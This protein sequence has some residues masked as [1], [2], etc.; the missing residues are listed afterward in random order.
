MTGPSPVEYVGVFA[1]A[2]LLTLLFVPLA[3]RVVLRR[4]NQRPAEVDAVA[5]ALPFFGGAAI[6]VAFS[7]IVFVSAL[8]SPPATQIKQLA[9]ALA[10]AVVLSLV[11]LIDDVRGVPATARLGAIAGASIGIWVVGVRIDLFPFEALNLALTIAWVVG[12]TTAFNL[13]DNIDGLSAGV[14]GIAGASFFV[15]AFTNHQYSVAALSAAL[16]G[17]AAGFLR[18]N[19][20]PA[21][22]RMGDAGSLFLGFLLSVIGIKLRFEA[23]TAVTFLVPVL[24]LGLAI[25]DTTLVVLT[26][27]AGGR[28]PFE[29]G[30][31]HA[32]HRLVAAGL[33]VPAALAL[34]YFA[35]LALGW[36]GLVTARLTD[37]ATAYLLAALPLLIGVVGGILLASS[38]PMAPP[39]VG[40]TPMGAL[41]KRAFDIVVGS[42]IALLA[43]P[44]IVALAVVSAV[45]LRAWPFFM[46]KRIGRHGRIFKFLKIRTLPPHAAPYALKSEFGDLQIPRFA[47]FL[48]DRHLDELPQLYAVPLGRM[49]LVGPRPK[50]PDEF[51]PVPEEYARLRTRVPQG[52]TCLWQV[53]VHTAGLP[54]DSPEY[55]YWYLRHWS[56][57]LDLWILWRTALTLVGAGREMSLEDVPVWMV[58]RRYAI[59]GYGVGD[60]TQAELDRR[61]RAG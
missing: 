17:C 18:H 46:Q 32:S 59:P 7:S 30:R 2:A 34:L 26:R 10:A 45:T 52:C 6:V 20:F 25:F 57:R 61:L 19:Y 1:G 21:R 47:R 5:D 44:I 37:P 40:L 49:S 53:G 31:D 16:A 60:P 36:L 50:M 15:I 23:P 9:G 42:V 24:V 28:S 55:D 14:A 43:T 29:G 12:I 27:V 4:R 3:F 48:R 33:P 35:A 51:E 11:G 38:L 8:L 39:I 41:M 58:G 22:T 54:S 13:L 56:M